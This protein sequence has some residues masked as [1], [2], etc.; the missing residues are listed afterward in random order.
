MNF[1]NEILRNGK[2]FPEI[3]FMYSEYEIKLLSTKYEVM[4]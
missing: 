3:A 4:F 2:V 1:Q